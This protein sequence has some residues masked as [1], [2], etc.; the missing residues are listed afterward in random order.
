MKFDGWIDPGG[1]EF[2]ALV[3]AMGLKVQNY[4]GTCTVYREKV[5]AKLHVAFRS[6]NHMGVS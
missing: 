2:S 1:N 5:I 4:F 6:G 3:Q